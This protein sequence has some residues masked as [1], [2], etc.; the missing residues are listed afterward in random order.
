MNAP[1]SIIV[2]APN[3]LGDCF[4]SLPALMA[5]RH[6]FPD[7][8][9]VV[10]ARSHL[11]PLFGAM[12]EIDD[13]EDTGDS[14][15]GIARAFRLMHR[16]IKLRGKKF[17]LGI[18]LTNSFSS[19]FWMWCAG[20]RQRIG[21]DRD[22]RGLLL[23]QS[24]Q[25]TDELAAAHQAEY[26]LNIARVAGADGK[27]HAP[28]LSV[29]DSWLDEAVTVLKRF[30]LSEQAYAVIAPVSAYGAVKDWP[31]DRFSQVARRL[32][33]N[34][35][36]AVLVTGVDA[37]RS[38]IEDIAERAGEGVYPCAGETGLKGF[39][40]LLGRASLF[41]GN[42]SGGAHAAAAFGV[43]TVVIFGITEPSRTRPL[44]A[45]VCVLGEGGDCTP[46][47]NS[48]RVR[49]AAKDALARISVEDVA[50]AAERL[51]SVSATA[52]ESSDD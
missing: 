47:L 19:A 12:Q 30:S 33:E 1:R 38:R 31:G 14:G 36:L 49:E 6:H 7:A 52:G 4:M 25:V 17:D 8:R 10:A 37:D 21:Y 48:S 28:E 40:A 11:L 50:A 22:G 43:P 18:L 29:P 42:D 45:S 9:L 27:L 34:H 13:T 26:Y 41:I 35:G 44:G 51:L 2:R 15:R 16:A 24:V 32:V 5:L 20:I 39:L 3:W 23:D 46:D